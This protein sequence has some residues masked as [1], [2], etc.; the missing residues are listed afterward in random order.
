MKFY[1]VHS[2]ADFSLALL[3][4]S[5][6]LR[7][8]RIE[9]GFNVSNEE[10]AALWI[11]RDVSHCYWNYHLTPPRFLASST[12]KNPFTFPNFTDK[13]PKCNNSPKKRLILVEN[14]DYIASIAIDSNTFW[15]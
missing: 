6:R 13:I 10:L 5:E 7:L 14:M 11:E 12:I 1:W 15:Q 4:G 3:G 2:R 9:D 8:R